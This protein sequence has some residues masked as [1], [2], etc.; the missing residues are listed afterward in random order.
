MHETGSYPRPDDPNRKSYLQACEVTLLKLDKQNKV[1]EEADNAKLKDEVCAICLN[2]LA[3]N[4]DDTSTQGI[5]GLI[6]QPVDTSLAKLPN[7]GHY[8][9]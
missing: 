2:E 5:N 7:C 4:L 1:Q 8:F 3:P 6:K 9:H